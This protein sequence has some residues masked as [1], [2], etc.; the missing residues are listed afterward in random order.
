MRRLKVEYKRLN[1]LR[2]YE[3]PICINIRLK[4]YQQHGIIYSEH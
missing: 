3:Q 4:F 2:D 1:E